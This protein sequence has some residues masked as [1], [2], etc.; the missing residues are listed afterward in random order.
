LKVFKSFTVCLLLVFFLCTAC[1][2]LKQTN[3]SVLSSLK[4]KIASITGRRHNLNPPLTTPSPAELPSSKTIEKQLKIIPRF[5]SS[6]GEAGVLPGEF[7]SPL[8]VAVDSEGNIFVADTQNNRIQKFSPGGE[9]LLKWGGLGSD[10]RQLCSPYNL[11]VTSENIV[12]VTD[13]MNNRIMSFTEDGAVVA[14]KGNDGTGI[15]QFHQPIGLA[16]SEDGYLFVV[17][18]GNCRVQKLKFSYIEDNVA[19]RGFSSQESLTMPG[20]ELNNS[21]NEKFTPWN[22]GDNPGQLDTPWGVAFTPEGEV[23]ITDM[24]NHRVQRFSPDGDYI[25]QWGALGDKPGKFNFPTGIAVD[26]EGIVYVSDTGNNRIEKFTIDGEFLAEW[27]KLGSGIGELCK[28]HG[29]AID[30]TTG[31]I[32]VADTGNNRIVRF[33]Y[34]KK[35]F[36]QLPFHRPTPTVKQEELPTI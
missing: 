10:L 26:K 12:Y 5:A 24:K 7:A 8:G 31:D 22:K 34:H 13:N 30:S 35:P 19:A 27:G 36:L 9:F 3:F 18:S 32:L 33:T 6:F 28:P 11:I 23:L 17:D 29:I 21:W 14:A 1:S 20:E 16:M 4:E 2:K 25:L 15:G